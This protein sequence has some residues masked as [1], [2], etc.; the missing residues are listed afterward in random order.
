[1]KMFFE[2][3]IIL[4]ERVEQSEQNQCNYKA[5]AKLFIQIRS[6]LNKWNNCIA[7]TG[8]EIGI[9]KTNQNAFPN[10]LRKYISKEKKD[11]L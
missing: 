2:V 5:Q 3:Q 9:L 1:M 7:D 11:V 10:S 4:N 6:E 8:H